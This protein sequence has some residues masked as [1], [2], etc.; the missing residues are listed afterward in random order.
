METWRG[1]ASPQFAK[2]D[3]EWQRMML[4]KYIETDE[5][6]TFEKDCSDIESNTT[7]GGA[8]EM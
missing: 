1:L 2:V 7:L 3:E 6:T 5:T 4:A 8:L